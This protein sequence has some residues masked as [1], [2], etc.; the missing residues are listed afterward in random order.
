MSG[1]V[2]G[3]TRENKMAS[4]ST[5]IKVG[6]VVKNRWIADLGTQIVLW[7]SKDGSLIRVDFGDGEID[8]C[9]AE[10]YVIA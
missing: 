3:V 6:D 1:Y 9:A 4:K 10:S 7:V 5:K 8:V 2:I